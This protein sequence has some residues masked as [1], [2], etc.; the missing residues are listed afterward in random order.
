[1][2]LNPDQANAAFWDELCGTSLARQLGIRD[3]SPAALQRFDDAYFALYPYLL[4]WVAPRRLAGK[5]VLEIGLGYGSLGQMLAQAEAEYTGLDIA[6][7][8]VWLMQQR[9]ALA[10]L[11]GRVVRGSVLR[12]PFPSG[13]FDCV[14]S[15]G[16]FHHTGNVQRCIDEC[17]RVLKPGGTLLFMVYNK[18]SFRRWVQW[19]RATWNDLVVTATQTRP[20]STAAVDQ[21]RAF[22]ANSAGTAAP[23]TVFLSIAELR[24]M[25]RRFPSVAFAKQNCDPLAVGRWHVP[26][27]R[28]LST[29]GRFLGLDIYV[30]AVKGTHRHSLHHRPAGLRPTRRS[31]AGVLA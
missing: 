21:R 27:A 7:T 25:L 15:I 18:F 20:A 12:L 2:H 17:H 9:L 1:M 16:C 3:H 29:L 10:G 24:R 4:P 31:P 14:V 30:K 6:R 23:E 8:P 26:R 13:C 19:P 11:P 28:L 5:A 22:D